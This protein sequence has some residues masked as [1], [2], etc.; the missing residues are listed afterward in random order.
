MA[1]PGVGLV[2]VRC[3]SCGTRNRVPVA[4]A[5]SP[6]CG[7]CHAPLPWA[8][9]AGDATFDAVAVQ[10][11]LPV[12]VDLWAPWC[13]PCRMV[14]PAVEQLAT[15]LA[16]NLKVVK[17]NVD[18]APGVAARFGARSI[19][20]LLVLSH[21]ETVDR[22]VGALPAREL[23]IRVRAALDRIQRQP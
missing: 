10:A 14:S 2:E 3:P 7:H 11:R 1:T 9:T 4:A 19:P 21:G 12:L 5:G 13:G 18:E 15:E 16:G 22:I 20:T 23:G 8:V 6:R 17:V